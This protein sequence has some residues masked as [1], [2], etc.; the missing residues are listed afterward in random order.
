MYVRNYSK[1][2]FVHEGK[3]FQNHISN[4]ES[5]INDF[6]RNVTTN[7]LILHGYRKLVCYSNIHFV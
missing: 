3:H 7:V 4:Q 2:S 1:L 6:V 5:N